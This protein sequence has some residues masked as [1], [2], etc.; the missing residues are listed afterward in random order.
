MVRAARIILDTPHRHAPSWNWREDWQTGFESSYALFSRFALWNRMTAKEV[1]HIFVS[2]TCGRRTAI[3]KQP[4]VDLRDAEAFDLV[5]MSHIMHVDFDAL[6][7]AFLTDYLPN[8]RHKSLEHLRWCTKCASAAFHSPIFQLAIIAECPIHS[9]PLQSKCKSCGT[10]I[11]YRFRTDV[12][13]TPFSCPKCAKPLASMGKRTAAQVRRSKA[14]S[15]SALENLIKLMAFEDQ[16][17]AMKLELNRL[18]KLQGLG[19]LVISRADWRR[20][21][22]E[23]TGFVAQVLNG[24]QA[25]DESRQTQLP[26]QH[27]LEVVRGAAPGRVVPTKIRLRKG[28]KGKAGGFPNPGELPPLEAGLQS[29]HEVYKAIRRHLWR[30]VVKEHR[31]CIESLARHLWWHMEGE[32]TPLVCP[33]AEAFVRWRM[34]WEGTGVPN[35]LMHA[36]N[37]PPY[38]IMCWQAESAPVCPAGWTPPAERWVIDH[39]F[40]MC[41]LAN[42][43]DWVDVVHLGNRSRQI[44]WT[45]HI[46]SGQ[47]DGYW[48]VTGNDSRSRPLHL[49][50]GQ[51]SQADPVQK[52]T[53]CR[54]HAQ[55]R[56]QHAT[57]LARIHR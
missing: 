23:Y 52:L 36:P 17:V 12:F 10:E 11:P 34:F 40:G 25:E 14:R 8:S 1:A 56:F 16:F 3:L 21:E 38:G 55:H 13:A 42:F 4:N 6:R 29:M 27:I 35:A 44:T 48:A 51:P 53:A 37:K 33:V 2:R 47:H 31:H 46:P 22:S 32:V 30:H 45:R 49:F 43:R 19:D 28:R 20:R 26:L 5:G 50:L 7:H 41:C 57:A 18:R 39:V 15:Y 24:L 9:L 54:C